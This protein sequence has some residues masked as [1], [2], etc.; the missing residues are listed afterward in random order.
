MKYK[1]KQHHVAGCGTRRLGKAYLFSYTKGDPSDLELC[2]KVM[3]EIIK[4]PPIWLQDSERMGI[5]KQG[6]SISEIG[7][8]YHAFDW[9]GMTEGYPNA[10]DILMEYILKDG[11]TLIPLRTQGLEKLI[12]GESKR[13]LCH[14]H[15]IMFNPEELL[16][17]RV[18]IPFVP[19]CFIPEG[20]GKDFHW[21]AQEYCASLH[22]QTCVHTDKKNIKDRLT[23]TTV[24]DLTYQCATP[25][26][27][28]V[29]Q[30][31]DAIIAAIDIHELHLV[32]GNMKENPPDV[33]DIIQEAIE[34]LGGLDLSLPIFLTNN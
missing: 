11:S 25:P 6:I 14:S 8:T 28:F 32:V 19:D 18:K 26:K 15:G 22:W 30:W 16:A 17:N 24:G 29:P 21:Q 27:G 23:T 7:G 1:H 20:I 33:N 31:G 4:D 34:Y 12:P 5:A 10:S 13:I 2:F 9:I 3:A